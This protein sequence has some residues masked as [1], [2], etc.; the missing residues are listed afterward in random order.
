MF[1]AA[2]R[3]AARRPLRPG[4]L[5]RLRAPLWTLTRNLT[6]PPQALVRWGSFCASVTFAGVSRCPPCC[7]QPRT[8]GVRRGAALMRHI[9]AGIFQTLGSV[10]GG[11]PS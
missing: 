2:C 1:P 7:S 3:G 9:R 6:A 10:C 11:V 8:L 5:G 4:G